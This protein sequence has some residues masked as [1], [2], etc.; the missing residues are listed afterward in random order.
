VRAH[1]GELLFR[2]RRGMPL[3]PR[4]VAQRGVQTAAAKAALGHV[5]PQT[6]RKSVCSPAAVESIRSNHPR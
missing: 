4:N 1:D 3:S 2:T 5:T 6:L